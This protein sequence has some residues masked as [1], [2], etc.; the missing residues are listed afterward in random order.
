MLEEKGHRGRN[1]SGGSRRSLA[2]LNVCIRRKEFELDGKWGQEC[3]EL[4]GGASRWQEVCQGALPRSWSVE[5]GE[6]GRLR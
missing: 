5:G 6:E 3:S 4:E 2:S 1:D